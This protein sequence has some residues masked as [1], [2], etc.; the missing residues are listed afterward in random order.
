MLNE[1][2]GLDA[3]VEF[4]PYEDYEDI[5]KLIELDANTSIKDFDVDKTVKEEGD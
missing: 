1:K 2:F 3:S 5:M 4:A